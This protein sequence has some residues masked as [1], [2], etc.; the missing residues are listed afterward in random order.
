M[1][2]TYNLPQS[3][4]GVPFHGAYYRIVAASMQRMR[5][6]DPESNAPRF[7]VMIDVA[8]YAAKP[9]SEDTQHIDFRRF[10]LPADAVEAKEGDTFMAKC[11][12]VIAADPVFAGCTS[13]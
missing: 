3:G 11:Y 6:D 13:C 9:D 4:F 7:A 12:A 10:H 8:G 2:I 5:V 1:A